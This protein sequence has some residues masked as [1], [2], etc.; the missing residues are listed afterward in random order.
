MLQP[1]SQDER[2]VF[3]QLRGRCGWLSGRDHLLSPPRQM[4]DG[5][6]RRRR[7]VSEHT[8]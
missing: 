2:A 3:A 6:P 7:S 4:A 1:Q 8:C 5:G